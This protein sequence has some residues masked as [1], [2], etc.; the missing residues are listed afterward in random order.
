[1][2]QLLALPAVGSGISQTGLLVGSNKHAYMNYYPSHVFFFFL[3]YATAHL[4]TY[5]IS[6]HAHR[7]I[8]VSRPKALELLIYAHEH[9]NTVDLRLHVIFEPSTQ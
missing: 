1:M 2:P 4:C 6:I 3:L 7:G 9:H 5:N 8:H